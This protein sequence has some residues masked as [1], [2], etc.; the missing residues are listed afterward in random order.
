MP[1]ELFER[2]LSD[3]L[4]S[5][6]APQRDVKGKALELLAIYVTR[7][8]DLDFKGWRIRSADTGG[9]EVDAVVEGARLIFTRWQIQAKNT[10]TVR[11]DDI[12]KEVG[13]SLTFLYSNVVMMV[14]TGAFTA[15]AHRYADH[16]M[17][18]SNLNVILLNGADLKRISLDPT[19]IAPLLNSKAERAMRLKKR[20]DYLTTR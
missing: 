13:L 8:I 2:S 7:L 9:A 19:D 20:D 4:A 15:D 17:K 11:L 5:L 6:K 12:A 1:K 16:V 10:A 14:T 3:I 18:T